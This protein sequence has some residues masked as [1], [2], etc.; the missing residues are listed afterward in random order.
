VWKI[1]YLNEKK[2]T[3]DRVT[4]RVLYDILKKFQ[5]WMHGQYFLFCFLSYPSSPLF[6]SFYRYTD[7]SPNDHS[8]NDQSPND[9]SSNGHS[10]N[11]QSP[12]FLKCDQSQNATNLRTT[13]L[14]MRPILENIPDFL[15]FIL[16]AC[17]NSVY[18]VGNEK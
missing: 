4:H 2:T 17:C 16:P 14:R 6:N 18:L 9:Q 10:P 8:P 12:N 5:Q 13:N 3:A 7:Q 15:M 11:D 1:V